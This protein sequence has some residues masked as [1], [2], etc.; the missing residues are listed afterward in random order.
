MY[1]LSWDSGI[2]FC[3]TMPGLYGDLECRAMQDGDVRAGI[4]PQS[5]GRPQGYRQAA[6]DGGGDGGCRW[7]H[8]A[9]VAYLNIL[10]DVLSSVAGTIVPPGAEPSRNVMMA[11]ITFLAAL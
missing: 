1:D 2:K 7:A 3:D 6:P 5:W 8:R 10:A 4:L 9:L 11:A